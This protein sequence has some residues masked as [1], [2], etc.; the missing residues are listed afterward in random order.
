[1]KN[2]Q[3]RGV[4]IPHLLIYTVTIKEDLI[5]KFK[6]MEELAMKGFN[7]GDGYMGLVDGKYILFASESDYYEYM[8][9]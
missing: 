9:D 4:F 2:R 1:M 8:N 7:T 6:E 5:I 3:L